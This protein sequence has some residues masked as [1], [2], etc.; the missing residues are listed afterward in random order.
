MLNV[1]SPA[2]AGSNEFPTTPVPVKVPP[3]GVPDKL[4]KP[5]SKQTVPG[6]NN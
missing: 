3:A 6:N 2:V 4:I 5:P 1:P